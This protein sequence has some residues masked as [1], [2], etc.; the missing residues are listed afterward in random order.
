VKLTFMGTGTSHGIPMVA[1]KCPV[2]TST[3]PRDRR[4]RCCLMLEYGG[5]SLIV[6]TPPEFRLQCVANEVARVD[7]LFF[8]HAH[9]D[10]IFGL[11][12]IR[13]YC[14]IQQQ[15]LP[16]Y[17]SPKTVRSLRTVFPYAFDRSRP[18][19]SEV[20]HLES[21][22]VTGPF[23]LFG[24]TVLPLELDHGPV[25]V[26]GFRIDDFAYCTDCNGIPPAT[27][28]RMRGLDVLVLDALRYSPHPTHFTV[29]QALEI[30]G[31]IDARRTYLTHIAHEIRHADLEAKL[32]P[33]TFL[34]YD[35]LRLSL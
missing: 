24:K 1:C 6:D 31:R 7:A 18:L 3:D 2:C 25:R 22:E 23:E 35:R 29:E 26:L 30:A 13:R 32:P 12:D 14:A 5:K 33:N 17:G 21:V 4:D 11:D 9:A 34:S 27:M 20:P 15:I 19:V 8:T 10:H 16:V 28:D